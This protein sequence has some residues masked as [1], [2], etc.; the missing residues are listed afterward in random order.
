MADKK[1]AKPAGKRELPDFI[2][3]RIDAKKAAAKKGK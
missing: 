1:P 3:K 2:Q